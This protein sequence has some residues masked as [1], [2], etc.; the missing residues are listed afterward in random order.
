MILEEKNKRKTKEKPKKTKKTKKNKK[1]KKRRNF[2][3]EFLFEGDDFGCGGVGK[4][5]KKSEV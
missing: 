3:C 1:N 5:Q 4:E 2:D